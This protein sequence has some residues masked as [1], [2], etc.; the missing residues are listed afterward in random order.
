MTRAKYAGEALQDLA[1]TP[2]RLRRTLCGGQVEMLWRA[3][4]GLDLQTSGCQHGT[5]P[6]E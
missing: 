2:S 1:A 6:V 4:M 3:H 5:C